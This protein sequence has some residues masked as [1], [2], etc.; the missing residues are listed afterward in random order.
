MQAKQTIFADLMKGKS[1][2]SIEEQDDKETD[3]L[4]Q[5]FNPSCSRQAIHNFHVS[6]TS[7]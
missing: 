1:V 6:V 7:I 5:L 3:H 4:C 2:Y